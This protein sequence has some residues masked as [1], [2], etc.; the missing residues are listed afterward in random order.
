MFAGITVAI[1]TPCV[2]SR[3]LACTR[4]SVRFWRTILTCLFCIALVQTAVALNP[5]I[6]R[7][8]NESRGLEKRMQSQTKNYCRYDLDLP[9]SGNSP[10][11]RQ[12]VGLSVTHGRGAGKSSA[13]GIACPDI[14]ERN[15]DNWFKLIAKQRQLDVAINAFLQTKPAM[16]E[17][18]N[19]KVRALQLSIARR[20]T[21]DFV[22]VIHE[23]SFETM[24]IA[25]TILDRADL[26]A[27]ES[28]ASFSPERI[29]VLLFDKIYAE[30]VH[31]GPCA[32]PQ[33]LPN[34]IGVPIDTSLS[35]SRQICN[36][37]G[38]QISENLALSN[39]AETLE[40]DGMGRHMAIPDEIWQAMQG[41]SWHV[42]LKCP[43]RSAL[44][45]LEIPYIGF[46]GTPRQ[47]QMIV[48]S[49]VAD[50]VLKVFSRLYKQKFKIERMEL[51]HK[52]D[53]K[54]IVS[55]KN[56]NT[57]AF[58]CRTVTGASRL[59]EHARG[60]AIDINP[61]Q[62][63]YVRR[64]KVIPDAGHAYKKPSQR[65]WKKRGKKIPGLV[66]TRGPVVQEFAKIGW[67]WG[68][69]WRSLKDYQHFSK[70]GR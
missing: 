6:E 53:G 64:G 39:G 67:K 25:R 68:G 2:R 7:L 66:Y 63:P 69:R 38:Q 8:E 26:L 34:E 20:M 10:P 65:K 45:L 61:V 18:L 57:S 43:K 62:N 40:N 4:L 35:T 56:N 22:R 58:N 60:H 21:C 54:D 31:P 47:G 17:G 24:E 16:D 28:E 13:T 3:K 15:K 70:S 51:V 11:D 19:K 23:D 30:T 9:R 46:D 1:I 59:S 44:R 55:R 41:K 14:T 32:P 49:D 27:S 12:D 5:E 33:C 52:F 42:R 48:A 50:D 29:G 37:S 36:S